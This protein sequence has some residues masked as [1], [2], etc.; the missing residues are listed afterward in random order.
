MKYKATVPITDGVIYY[1]DIEAN[2]IAEALLQVEQF[3]KD[4]K[5][6][7]G[8]GPIYIEIDE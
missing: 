2:T 7:E 6:I 8:D 3:L 1:E 4:D 5:D